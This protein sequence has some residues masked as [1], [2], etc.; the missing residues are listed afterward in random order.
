MTNF[1]S[2]PAVG[3]FC[4]E[5]FS[6][7]CQ[8]GQGECQRAETE[9]SSGEPEDPFSEAFDLF[10]EARAEQA[11]MGT[12]PNGSTVGRVPSRVQARDEPCADPANCDV[13]RATTAPNPPGVDRG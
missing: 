8:A 9:G 4:D 10:E 11:A 3:E 1:Q 6:W 7:L 13:H 12:R 5:H 2:G